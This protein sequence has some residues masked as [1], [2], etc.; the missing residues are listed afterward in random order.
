MATTPQASL[1]ATADEPLAARMRPR[2][3]DEFVGQEH[4]LGP[5]RLLRRAIVADRLSSVIFHG[6]PGTGKTTLARVVAGSTKAEFVALNAV[7]S[8][9]K[10]IREQV[11]A[12]ADRQRVG[13]RTLLF[14][15]EVHRFN[16]AQQDALLPSVE[17][18][19]VTFIGAT[20]ENPYFEV[21]PALVSRSRVFQLVPLNEDDLRRV[22]HAALT[23][24][25]RGFGRLDVAL[26][27]DALDHLVNI[28]NGDA[29][30][31]LNALELAVVTTEPDASGTVRI[32]RPTAEESI[33]R[34]A[35]LYDKEGDAH[36]DVISAFIKSVR[37]SDPDA[38]LYWLAK[39]VHAGEDPRFV[40]R[41]L[42]IL[43]SEDIGL[44]DP[45]ALVHTE[46]AAQAFEAVGMPEGRYH[47][48]QATLYLATAPKSNS[49]MAFFDALAAVQ[50]EGRGEVPS[51]LK[52]ASRDAEG[53]GHG[54]GYLYPHAY[55]DHW[56]AQQYLPDALQGRLF[57]QPSDQGAEAEI[58]TA[59]ARRRE[60]QLAAML[61]EDA[62]APP[63]ILS[64]SPGDAA[65]DRWAARTLSGR[66]ERMAALRDAAFERLEV[67]RHHRVLDL[68][69]G[70]GWTTF[71]A[72]RRAPEGETWAVAQDERSAQTI[73]GQTATLPELERPVVLIADL[74]SAPAE[75]RR[76]A[77]Q[78]SDSAQAEGTFDRILAVRV[79]ADDEAPQ[80]LE[81]LRSLL[82]PGGR[83]VFGDALPSAGTRLHQAVDLA[84]L[85]PEVADA[86]RNAE[87]DAYRQ[88][89][90]ARFRYDVR[91]G[92]E[93]LE[94]A[95]FTVTHAETV[96]V[97]EVRRFPSR[98]LDGWF[99]P[100]APFRSR[101]EAAGV[102]ATDVADV[103]RRFRSALQERDVPWRVAWAWLRA[104][105]T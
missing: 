76:V 68:T 57:Y 104:T 89:A 64:W 101:L 32:D 75:I 17:A 5:G 2:T 21:N 79:L 10:D 97:D 37:G 48:A 83:A 44:A 94:A 33:Q 41:R 90:E 35:V 62:Q 27:D 24:A 65:R 86:V 13:R 105:A 55:R 82:A 88:A 92:T 70:S 30:S 51:H 42:R 96:E 14:I 58:R 84:G 95:G 85:S 3:I 78:R 103:E 91:S 49:T 8:G 45:Q 4:V 102:D 39:M 31:L 60:A 53:F 81:E 72:L 12:A 15:D 98:A 16:K 34:R 61:D 23:D 7:L 59:V 36:F 29:R 67:A 43:A 100:D 38:A 99:G 74:A 71:E 25:E 69:G 52:D 77:A 50:R 87:E 20:T 93:R 63:E 18:G 6:P 22:A 46:A 80:A 54:Q 26:D 19:T 11:A 9:V 73:R 47:L 1:F 28:A 40:L 66:G 56:V